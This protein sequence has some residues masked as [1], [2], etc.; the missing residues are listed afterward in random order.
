MVRLEKKKKRWKWERIGREN[1]QRRKVVGREQAEEEVKRMG[2][3]RI[4]QDR[5]G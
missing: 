3:D 5:T 1:Y 4:G 2:Q